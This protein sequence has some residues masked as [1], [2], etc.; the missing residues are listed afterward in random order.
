MKP[1]RTSL[2]GLLFLSILISGIVVFM[3][4]SDHDKT[5]NIVMMLGG[6]FGVVVGLF[7]SQLQ[8]RWLGLREQSSYFTVPHLQRSVQIRERLARGSLTFCGMGIIVS[9]VGDSLHL[10]P[11]LIFTVQ[12]VFF[13]LAALGIL[14]SLGVT[15]ANWRV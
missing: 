15:I 7:G 12:L 4:A 8:R 3:Q 1:W 2:L 10:S 11:T 6:A 5:A 13:G 14:I 9:A